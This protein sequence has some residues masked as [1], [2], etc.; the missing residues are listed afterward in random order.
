MVQS[1]TKRRRNSESL[2]AFQNASHQNGPRCYRH[3][4]HVLG[5]HSSGVFPGSSH[6]RQAG[7]PFAHSFDHHRSSC[8]EFHGQPD[9]LQLS[10]SAIPSKFASV[11]VLQKGRE[12]S[13]HTGT[14][15]G[16]TVLHSN[17]DNNYRILNDAFNIL[18]QGAYH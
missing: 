13:G 14:K 18:V 1:G 17:E 15:S 8:L 7:C 6:P 11:I 2:A 3:L 12:K 10:E 5:S 16:T 4:R 9:H